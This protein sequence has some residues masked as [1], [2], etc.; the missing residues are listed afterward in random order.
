[1]NIKLIIYVFFLVLVQYAASGQVPAYNVEKTAFSSDKY[2]EFSP[3]F[4]H[5]GIVFCS[6]RDNNLLINYSPTDNNA[7]VN[8]F[9]IDTTEKVTWRKPRTFSRELTTRL[10]EGPVTFSKSRDTLYYCRNQIVKGRISSVSEKRNRLGLYKAVRKNDVWEEVS[11]FR[12]NSEWYNIT[13][14]Y[15]SPDGK[16][17]YFAADMPEGYG[18]SDIYYSTREKG[19]WSEPVNLGPVVNSEGNEAYPFINGT[20]E[21][22]F[23]S[24]NERGY[25]GKDIY[26]TKSVDGSWLK[27]VLLDQPLNSEFDD[28]GLIADATFSSGYF[29]T[30]RDGSID[31]Y[32]FSEIYP[33]IFYTDKQKPNNYCFSF[34]KE[35]NIRFGSFNLEYLW[36][37]GDGVKLRGDEVNYCFPGPGKYTVEQSVIDS[38]TGS[39]FFVTDIKELEL[40]KYEQPVISV[41]GSLTVNNKI[42]VSA[43]DS[44]LPGYEIV[45]YSWDFGDGTRARGPGS[46]HTYKN[47]GEYKVQLGVTV[48][49]K[50]SRK[51]F[52]KGVH[53]I[54]NVNFGEMKGQDENQDTTEVLRAEASE[55]V[56]VNQ[57]FSIFRE[58]G[59][60][61]ISRVVVFT[62]ETP[63]NTDN[64][65]YDNLRDFTYIKQIYSEEDGLYEYV[66][67]EQLNIMD[68]YLTF[69]KALSLGYQNTRV[70][71]FKAE[72][73]TE[74]SL[75]S[76]KKVFKLSTDDFFNER[77]DRLSLDILHFLDQLVRLM[78][79]NEELRLFIG[80]HSDNTAPPQ[81]N[82]RLTRTRANTIK[83]YMI[84][85]GIARSRLTASGFGNKKPRAY[86]INEEGRSANRRVEIIFMN[87]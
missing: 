12:F 54:V 84:R 37:F 33:Q 58:K 75:I 40:L 24:D 49:E 87:D 43:S 69:R 74:E 63:V 77:S 32:K 17:L 76:L 68:T 51:I 70:A 7:H 82:L 41:E 22:F 38:I 55:Q 20:G 39:V 66:I 50:D 28:F 29:S 65:R 10:S 83:E 18:G 31:I 44:Y 4:Y 62:S 81:T 59:G 36:D 64:T 45:N 6:T 23:S 14:P 21:M 11:S 26:Y 57:I 15:L 47:P 52:K 56:S 85:Q 72:S 2:D 5:S 46:G 80:V 53:R 73:Q 16:R 9:F 71:I 27:P 67:D 86:N 35:S 25:G 30:N 60:D 79:D 34:K 19:Y 78:E 61:A 13:T 8:I 3:V 42:F 1:M 48:R